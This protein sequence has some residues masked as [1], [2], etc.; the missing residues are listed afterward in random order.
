MKILVTGGHGF[1]GSHVME[2]LNSTS[3]EGI[4]LSRRDGIDM[5]NVDDALRAFAEVK[6]DIILNCAAH[7]GSL[8][9]VSAN[10][11]DVVTDN[12]RIILNTF[13]AAHRVVPNARIVNPISNCAYPGDATIQNEAEFWNGPVHRSVYS[14]GNPRR[15]I[16]VT[17]ECY[18]SQFGTDSVNFIVP[19]AYGPGDYLDPNRTHA[20]N[21]MIIRMLQAKK[22]DA[23]RFEIWGTGKPTREWIFVKD[24]ATML[25]DAAEMPAPQV[26][27]INLAQNR[28]YSIRESAELIREAL[29]YRGE[30][31][32]DSSKQDGAMR[33]QL[34]DRL[35]RQRFPEFVF[36][37]M[38]QGIR[39]TIEYYVRAFGE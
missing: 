37:P 7:V 35:F 3:H 13:D 19:N 29:G 33:K 24:I 12:M 38:N 27:P 32:F 15:M 18:H 2:R 22:T 21:G 36:T 26:Q 39:T 20:L 17:A 4:A 31:Y 8:N 6:P 1:V 16:L 28:S 25:V 9:Y 11:G 30:L 5:R 23:P 34:G 14:Y 10:A